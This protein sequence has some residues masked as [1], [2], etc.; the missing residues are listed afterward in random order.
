MEYGTPEGRFKEAQ[1]LF[2]EIFYEKRPSIT[3]MAY[4]GQKLVESA[5]DD[6]ER[7]G[8]YL[9]WAQMYAR[10][11]LY[12][13]IIPTL[14]EARSFAHAGVDDKWQVHC[15]SAV[16]ALQESKYLPDDSRRHRLGYA[17]DQVAR[18]YLL[19]K[20]D[21]SCH[22]LEYVVILQAQIVKAMRP[23]RLTRLLTY[24]GLPPS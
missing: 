15:L 5:R 23:P 9:Q 13:Q 11:Q 21:P 8:A 12:S 4:V 14:D 20:D 18:A 16:A 7:F 17:A 19:I 24:L 3:A 1:R 6:R 2:D 22:P 10:H